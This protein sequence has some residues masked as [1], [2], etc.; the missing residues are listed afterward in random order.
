MT[1][2]EAAALTIFVVVVMAVLGL[3][4]YPLHIPIPRTRHKF[5]LHYSYVPVLGV[6]LMLACQGLSGQDFVRGIVGEQHIQPYGILILFMALAYMS[7]S[8]DMT[9]VFAWLALRIT[10][11]SRGRGRLL[12]ILYFVLS[13]IVTTFTS[14]DVSIMTL[15]PIIYYFASATSADP[16]PFLTA[17]FT[18]ANIWSMA[19]FIGNPTNIIVASAVG[20]SF[21][22]YSKWMLLPTLGKDMHSSQN[23][24]RIATI[25]ET[26]P[27]PVTAMPPAAW[28]A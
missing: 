4:L 22:D 3:V 26:T 20:M 14:N 24:H 13:G 25:N 23:M 28:A 8:L 10:I 15:T 11:Q 16:I 5:Q 7:A 19:L 9:G 2:Q 12:F 17:E 6:L 18:S 1:F 21:L 27:S